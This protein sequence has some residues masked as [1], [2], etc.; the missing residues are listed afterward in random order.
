[1]VLELFR[2]TYWGF[3]RLENEHLRNTQ[4]FRR[5]D[6][7][8]LHYDHGVGASSAKRERVLR[9]EPL[10]GHVFLAKILLIL[11]LVLALSVLAIL[12]EK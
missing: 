11:F 3:F 10:A 9:D 12:V 5:V 7:I 4:G 1:M 6:F 2:R 8:P